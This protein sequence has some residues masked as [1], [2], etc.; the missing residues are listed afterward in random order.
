V[1]GHSADLDIEQSDHLTTWFREGAPRVAAVAPPVSPSPEPQAPAATSPR[2]KEPVAPVAVGKEPQ[3]KPAEKPKPP[4]KLR[5]R[6]I[7]TWVVRQPAAEAPGAAAS[8]NE[9]TAVGVKY[10]LE[11]ARCDGM[12]TVHQDPADATKPRGTDIIGSL[13]LIEGSPD[14]NKLTVF[15]WEN[16]PG[17]VHNEGT[18]LIGPKVVVDQIHNVVRVE[19][20]GAFKMPSSS[21]LTGA[22][23]RNAE[24]VVVQFRDG[25]HFQGALK[26][27][28]FFGKVS[29]SQGGSWVSCH[30][31]Q[32]NF[33]R[34]IYLTQANRPGSPAPPKGPNA[35]ADEKAKIDRVF[36]WPAPAD[37]ADTPRDREVWFTQIDRDPDTGRVVRHQRL[38]AY[39]L[40]LNAQAR[41]PGGSEPYREIKAMG[42]G[43]VRTWQ[44][45]AKDEFGQQPAAGAPKQPA[46]PKQ[47]EQ[48]MKLTEV[49][50]E[51]RMVA[52]DKGKAYQSATFFQSIQVVQV[53]TDNPDLEIDPHRLPPRA[54]NLTCDD[55]LVVW[56]HR[57]GSEPAEQHMV[58][59]G[60][61]YVQ[62]ES[63]DG[64]GEVITLEGK[65]VTLRGDGAL[66]ARIK[67]R[68]SGDE[69]IGR[70][71][72]YDRATN[73]YETEKS[74]DGTISPP[75][76]APKT[77]PP[78]KK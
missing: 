21:D 78:K 44:V 71:I 55:H 63:Y 1:T 62:N 5:A 67:G 70:V 58:A 30:T 60:N 16:R 48:E 25:M 50:Y 75:P 19:G 72:I 38:R 8:P 47:A 9:R 28:D 4:T 2:P 53:P 69:Q 15:G 7:D 59:T 42:P 77:P 20:R 68:F 34:P 52:H 33:D 31:L 43:V 23:L 56:A 64:W 73:R 61:A 49:R 14:G 51:G 18:S 35:R 6:T 17:E 57:K 11:N 46:A 27:A 22:T 10:Q 45:G 40:E 65:I 24:V 41:D 26:R 76:P 12:V 74:I 39:E 13:M 54:V 66:H 32:V 3:P 37:T 29:A 36:C